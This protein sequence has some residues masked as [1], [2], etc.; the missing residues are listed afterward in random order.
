M[1]VQLIDIGANLTHESFR[2]DLPAVLDRAIQHGVDRIICTG[3]DLN[4]SQKALEL[5]NTSPRILYATAGVH[6]HQAGTW[7]QD[8]Q[9]QLH[10][11]AFNNPKIKALGEMG[12][13][14][15]RDFS[16][17]TIQEKV[18]EMQLEIACTLKKPVFLHQRDAHNSFLKILKAYRS[19]LSRGVVHCFTGNENELNDYLDLDMHIGITGWICDERRGFHLKNI[20]KKIPPNRL[21]IETDAP[22]LLPRDLNPPPKNRRNEPMHLR[23]I[24]D[25][26]A[27]SMETSIEDLARSTSETAT[28]FFDLDAVNH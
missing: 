8:S 6:P 9:N 7:Q 16:P 25:V 28:L 20:I 14:F 3:S 4:D 5:S 19:K 18:F 11:L 27:L 21:M 17:R 24:A 23:H 13:D 1:S 12:L 2:N 15:N 10:D 26:I 22:Y